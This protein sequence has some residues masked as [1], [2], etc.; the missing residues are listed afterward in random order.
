MYVKK[1]I[2]A[3]INNNVA[4]GVTLITTWIPNQIETVITYMKILLNNIKDNEFRF[5]NN[6]YLDYIYNVLVSQVE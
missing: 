5:E 4:T 3:N 2:M 1:Y 6:T